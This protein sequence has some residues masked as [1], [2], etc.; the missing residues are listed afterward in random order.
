[1]YSNPHEK[2]LCAHLSLA[3]YNFSFPK[4][5]V[6]VSPFFKG[7]NQYARYANLFM[8]LVKDN[9][10]EL[11]AMRVIEGYLVTHVYDK[12]VANIVVEG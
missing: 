5:L 12:G 9:I 2:N 1:M 6:E 11:T 10:Y 3:R 7:L 8:T 4:F